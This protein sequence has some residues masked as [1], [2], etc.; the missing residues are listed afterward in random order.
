LW[1]TIQPLE[2]QRPGRT[3]H[4]D[5]GNLIRCSRIDLDPRPTLGLKDFRQA[6]KAIPSMNAQLRL[7]QDGDLALA[8]VVLSLHARSLALFVLVVEFALYF[9][10]FS[11]FVKYH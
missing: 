4:D 9:H 2:V 5:L 10:I 7:P 11:R 1:P 3:F 8:V 6:A